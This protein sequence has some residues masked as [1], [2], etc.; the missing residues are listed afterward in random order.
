MYIWDH[1]GSIKLFISLMLV[2]LFICFLPFERK[3]KMNTRLEKN[4]YTRFHFLN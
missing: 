2:D 3:K 4:L 1:L